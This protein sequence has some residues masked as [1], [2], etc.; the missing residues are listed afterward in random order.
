MK[1]LIIEPLGVKVNKSGQLYAYSQ[2]INNML[3]VS[4][5][6]PPFSGSGSTMFSSGRILL[7]LVR[8]RPVDDAQFVIVNI[9]LCEAIPAPL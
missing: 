8:T 5:F 4:A 1:R 3:G 2:P 9:Q 7:Q 6:K